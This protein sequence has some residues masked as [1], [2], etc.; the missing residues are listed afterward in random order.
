MVG[1]DEFEDSETQYNSDLDS[2]S[3]DAILEFQE[4]IWEEELRR[5]AAGDITPEDISI[6]RAFALKVTNGMPTRTFNKLAFVFPESP[7]A[8][9]ETTERWAAKLSGFQPEKY[10]CCVDSCVLFVGPHETLQRCP[11]PKC[12]KARYNADGRPCKQFT[13]LP[14]IPRLKALMANFETAQQ[15]QYRA[16]E[17]NFNPSKIVDVFDGDI[18]RNLLGKR[19]TVNGVPQSHT[20]FCDHRDIAMGLATDGFGPFKHRKTTAWPL[21]LYN[22]NLPP[23]LRFCKG[24]HLPLGVI[25]GPKKPHDFDSFMWPM[26]QELA[27]LEA[28]VSAFDAMTQTACLLRAFLIIVFGDIPAVS[29]LMRMKGHNGYSPCRFC[30]IK[31]VRGPGSKVLYVPLDRREFISVRED[32]T[33]VSR[34]DPLNLPKRTHKEFLEQATQVQAAKTIGEAEQRSKE[35]GIKGIPLLSQLTALSFPRSF[36]YE[37]MHLIFENT[38]VNLHGLWTTNFKGLNSGTEEYQLTDRQW[39]DIWTESKAACRTI[40]STMGASMPNCPPDHIPWT[41]DSRCFWSLYIA[42]VVLKNRFHSPRVYRHFIDLVVLIRKCIK[43]EMPRTDV[44]VIC[45]GFAQWVLEY[46]Q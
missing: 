2:D 16:K 32:P 11:N 26:V 46:E 39:A 8:P 7:T 22:Y 13:Y 5:L 1:L 15:M 33:S 21:I 24:F 42:P 17:Y 20:Y 34:Y 35:C 10:D 3:D 12:N 14:I 37:F 18:Y 9:W 30:H 38:L 45:N 6:L 31:G 28:G 41:A 23:E 43:F 36:P 40:P 44:P 25:P 27:Q 4:E 19:V 29:M